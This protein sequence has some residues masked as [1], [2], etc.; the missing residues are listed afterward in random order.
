MAKSLR[1]YQRGEYPPSDRTRALRRFTAKVEINPDGCWIW[2]GA[3]IINR[4]GEEYGHFWFDGKARLAHRVAVMLFR[5]FESLPKTIEVGHQCNTPLCC[6]PAH[7]DLGSHV[8]NM[9][10]MHRDGRSN[11][12]PYPVDPEEAR[13]DPTKIIPPD[14]DVDV[15]ALEDPPF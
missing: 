7:T 14:I 10:K 15:D 5:G 6:N 8:E 13:P 2:T 12:N 1:A 4:R 3:T 11:G 9:N